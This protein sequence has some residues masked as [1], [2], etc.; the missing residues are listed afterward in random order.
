MNAVNF[1]IL[2]HGPPLW[3][4]AIL[5][6][7][8]ALLVILPSILG[9]FVGL[10][11]PTSVRA[12]RAGGHPSSFRPRA[13]VWVFVRALA[14]SVVLVPLAF[15]LFGTMS[16]VFG[17]GVAGFVLNAVLT[18]ISVHRRETTAQHQGDQTACEKEG[19]PDE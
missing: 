1:V 18:R 5:W 9:G 11:W 14:L 2:G 12:D 10:S 3:F 4:M 6:G 7:G 17:A 19:T 16:A 8:L 13:I 15:V